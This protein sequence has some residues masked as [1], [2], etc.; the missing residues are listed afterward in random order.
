MSG[1]NLKYGDVTIIN[2]LTRK[3]EETAVYDESGT[4]LLYH[5]FR[6]R[7]VGYCHSSGASARVGVTTNVPF[8]TATSS[9]TALRTALMEPRKSFQFTVNG[10]TLLAAAANGNRLV[11]PWGDLNN[12]PKPQQCVVVK[13]AGAA[14]YQVEFEIE[15]CVLEC[16]ENTN[17]SGVLSNRWSMSDVIDESFY[18]TRTITGK[19]RVVAAELNAQSFRSF[20][21]PPLQ[22]GFRRQSIS[23]VTTP[24]GLTMEYNIVD[25][26]MYAAPPFPGCKW[27][28]THTVSTTDG[29]GIS[30]ELNILLVGAKDTPKK[31]LIQACTML[32]MSR[33]DRNSKG[34]QIESAAIVDH[35][36]EN[37]VEMRLVVRQQ[38]D[39]SLALYAFDELNFGKILT[40]A[41]SQDYKR[42]EWPIPKQYGT[43]TPTGLFACYLQTPCNEKHNVPQT[44]GKPKEEKTPRGTEVFTYEGEGSS[45]TPSI[46]DGVFNPTST[47]NMYTFYQI[48]SDY[49]SDELVVGMPI[50]AASS[51][52]DSDSMAF[53]TLAKSCTKRIIKVAAERHGAWPNVPSAQKIVDLGGGVTAKLMSSKLNP[54]APQLTPDGEHYTYSIDAEYVYGLSK[55]I[56]SLPSIAS[57]SLPWLG[58]TLNQTA[59]Q[60]SSLVT[61]I[62]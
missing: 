60:P 31:D 9:Q 32:A 43:A 26:E 48:D 36:H 62:A 52:G 44:V 57:G 25:V 54:K 14:L 45:T 42:E 10:Q 39:K 11:P 22:L 55:P 6:I 34:H 53:I 18:T 12:G 8:R 1:T 35:M 49:H 19:L 23:I 61:G 16:N 59:L 20:V 56:A 28:A 51:S 3:F 7:V 38:P 17:S 46:G 21:I 24:D 40:E 5:Q 58:L 47:A 29:V 41:E 4:D 15:V 30:V 33:C 50:A 2:C 13:I 37:A 27:E